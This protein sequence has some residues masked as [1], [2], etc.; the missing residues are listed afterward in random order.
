M[1]IAHLGSSVGI[2]E[3]HISSPAEAAKFN[4]GRE[5]R[6][7]HEIPGYP[8]DDGA[9]FCKMFELPVNLGAMVVVRIVQAVSRQRVIDSPVKADLIEVSAG[10]LPPVR[11]T[12]S[13]GAWSREEQGTPVFSWVR[14]MDIQESHHTYSPFFGARLQLSL[15][16][17]FCKSSIIARL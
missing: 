14:F 17:W 11:L 2:P 15:A 8:E 4:I 5:T 3:H 6:E 10:L 16:P 7:H 1:Q 13:A 12:L 9:G